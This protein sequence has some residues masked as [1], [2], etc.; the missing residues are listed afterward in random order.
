MQPQG[1]VTFDGPYENPL[2][3]I[4]ANYNLKRAQDKDLGI[5]VKLQGPLVPYPGITFSSNSDFE[6]AQSDLV[7]YMLTGKP[8]FDFGANAQTSQVL[9][10]FLGPTVSAYTADKLRQHA[11]L[12]ARLPVPAWHGGSKGR[13]RASST[14]RT[15]SPILQTSTIGAGRRSA[16]CRST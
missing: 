15:S 14:P 12:R 16:P 7:S 9:A 5:I 6:I 2:L 8:G 3:N 10:S 1:T 13:P 4:Q 11:R